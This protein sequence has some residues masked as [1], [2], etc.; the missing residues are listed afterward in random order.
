MTGIRRLP[1]VVPAF[2]FLHAIDRCITASI[3][4]RVQDANFAIEASM[5]SWQKEEVKNRAAEEQVVLCRT[6]PFQ[7]QVDR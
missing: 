3:L 7:A 1:I 6:S 2:A 4:L 5:P